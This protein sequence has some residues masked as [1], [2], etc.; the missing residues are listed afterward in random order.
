MKTLAI[1]GVA[2]MTLVAFA[3]IAVGD[4]SEN[5]DAYSNGSGIIGQGGWE[6]WDGDP[7]WDAFVTD[8]VSR[9]GPHSVEITPSS[10]IIQ[11]FS[12]YTSG[13]ILVSAWC[14]VP[15]TATGE[16]YFILLDQY[17]HGGTNHWALQVMFG[18]G[19]VESQFDN[20]A[21]DLIFDQWVEF[22]VEISFDTDNMHVEYGGTTLIDKPWT[23]GSSNDGLGIFNIACLD[24]FSNAGDSIYWDDLSI[25]GGLTAT[26]GAT[27]GQV[28]ALY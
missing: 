14:Y 23:L 9:S 15:S 24:L 10:D 25:T 11:Q 19:I 21:I 7:V 28:K 20:I 16:Q 17:A 18:L 26:E 4:W 8:F 6:G 22:T 13:Q 2:L 1:L 27:W 5:F 3:T 12:G